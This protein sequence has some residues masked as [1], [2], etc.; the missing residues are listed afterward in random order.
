MRIVWMT[1]PVVAP[2][3]AARPAARDCDTGLG[4]EQGHVRPRRQA[5]DDRGQRIGGDDRQG[6]EKVG[7]HRIGPGWGH[8][9]PPER[10]WGAP[11]VI[12]TTITLE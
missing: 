9:I 8:P 1:S 12:G 6:G 10:R 4:Q 5:E 7:D 11:A 2:P 3:K